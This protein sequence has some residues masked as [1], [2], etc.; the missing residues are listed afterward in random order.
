MGIVFYLILWRLWGFV[1]M[2]IGVPFFA[3]VYDVITRLVMRGLRR[4]QRDDMLMAYDEQ[5]VKKSKI[6]PRQEKLWSEE[7][8]KQEMTQEK[9]EQKEQPESI[10]N[11]GES[12]E[13]RKEL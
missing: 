8:E 11:E 12:D 6:T 4:N 2:I 13:D 1:G 10:I 5:Y 3:V 7:E 9:T